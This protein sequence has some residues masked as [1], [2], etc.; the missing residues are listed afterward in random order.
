M[1]NEDKEEKKL[2]FVLKYYKHGKLDSAKAF[3]KITGS[4][5]WHNT[6]KSIISF[7][8]I[9][10]ALF[11]CIVSYVLIKGHDSSIVS[12]TANAGIT[13]YYMPDSTLAVL[14]K[15]SSVNYDVDKYGKKHRKVNMSGKVYFSVQRNDKVPFTV[16]G[17]FAQIN[18]LGTEFELEEL[19]QDSI[20]HVYVKSGKVVF[21]GKYTENRIVLTK[22]MSGTLK[23]GNAVPKISNSIFIN[24]SAW[25]TGKFIY[26]NTPID[27]VMKELSL[28]YNTNLYSSDHCKTLTGEFKADN[29]DEIITLIERTL[30][31][32]ITK[33]D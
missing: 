7:L 14:S 15:G 30:D 29:L 25:A 4:S 16:T 20:A 17:K 27:A 3:K 5:H 28:F 24:P 12:I 22:G 8:S 21:K 2:Q 13:R 11:I 33:K 9:A 31:I 32:E 1:E 23:S 10:A 18:V 6:N 26:K 19:Q